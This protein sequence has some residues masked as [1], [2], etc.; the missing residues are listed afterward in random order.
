MLDFRLIFDEDF[1]GHNE[2]PFPQR[3]GFA[4][5]EFRRFPQP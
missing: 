2:E 5:F 3:M 4:R 1:G